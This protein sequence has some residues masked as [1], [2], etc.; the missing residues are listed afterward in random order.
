LYPK[1]NFKESSLKDAVRK[2]LKELKTG[3]SNEA[4]SE[5]ACLQ[6]ETVLQQLKLTDGHAKRNILAQRQAIISAA[7]NSTPSKRKQTDE[8]D[9]DVEKQRPSKAQTLEMQAKTIA[10][11]SYNFERSTNAR[12]AYLKRKTELLERKAKRGRLSDLKEAKALGLISQ[13]QFEAEARRLLNLD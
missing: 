8:A 2:T 9:I 12:E 6:K 3:T 4:G 13:E 10:T 1:C 7:S 11:L 5:K